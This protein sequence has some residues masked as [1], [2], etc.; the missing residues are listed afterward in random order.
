MKK[1]II[2]LLL[3]LILFLFIFFFKS[4]IYRLSTTAELTDMQ[5]SELYKLAL[6]AKNNGNLP[7]SSLLLYNNEIIGEGYNTIA[8]DSD[9]SGHAEINALKEAINKIGLNEFMKME[10]SRIKLVTTLEPCEMCKGVFLHYN[11]RNVHFIK[12]KSFSI[13]ISNSYNEIRYQLNKKQISSPGLLDSLSKL[14]SD[15]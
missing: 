2:A 12:E 7:I 8:G 10:R 6:R 4:E 5:K 14:H 9:I 15:Y 3:L 13:N 1:I 11:I